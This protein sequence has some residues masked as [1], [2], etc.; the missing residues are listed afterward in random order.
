MR[1]L[2]STV[3]AMLTASSVTV[4]TSLTAVGSSFFG[5]TLAVTMAVS[6]PVPS[7]TV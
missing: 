4:N 7:L 2:A 1:S 3:R 6:S 5:A